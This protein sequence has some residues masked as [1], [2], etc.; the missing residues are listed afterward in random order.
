M[1]RKSVSGGASGDGPKNLAAMST[2]TMTAFKN[3]VQHLAVVRYDD[4]SPRVPGRLIVQTD[5]GN[6]T[7][8][9]KDPDGQC[10]LRATAALLDDAL[11]LLDTLLGSESAP[12][13]VDQWAKS[14]GP[15]KKT[16]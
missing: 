8:I 2:K 3:V 13:E 11:T 10:Q 1:K 6:W 15:R 14:R 4:G 9:A 16:G 7:V 12:W 5:G